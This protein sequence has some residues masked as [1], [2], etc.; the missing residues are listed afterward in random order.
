MYPT[1]RK[2]SV[3]PEAHF[4]PTTNRKP[5]AWGGLGGG[6]WIGESWYHNDI[7]YVLLPR[8]K[9]SLYIFLYLYTYCK[10]YTFWMQKSTRYDVGRRRNHKLSMII[11]PVWECWLAAAWNLQW[12][13]N[14]FMNLLAMIGKSLRGSHCNSHCWIC[15]PLL[16]GR[17]F[18]STGALAI[19]G[20]VDGDHAVGSR[21][22]PNDTPQDEHSRWN[23]M[24]SIRLLTIL[25]D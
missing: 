4:V 24:F 13:Y 14:V 21:I 15:C 6:Y 20:W 2:G 8:M 9:R 16:V 19:S 17:A 5:R 10:L 3:L 23:M 25:L 12:W 1:D 11:F 18:T 7:I 22:S